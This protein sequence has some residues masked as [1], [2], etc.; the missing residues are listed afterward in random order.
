MCD[1]I[2]DKIKRLWKSRET[3]LDVL[4]DRGY[5][6]SESHI[7]YEEFKEWADNLGE[8]IDER[9]IREEMRLCFE[10]SK[11]DIIYVYWHGAKLGTH[12]SEL[13]R[14]M[15]KNSITRAIIVSDGGITT[16]GK[17]CIK[18]LRKYHIDIYT[19]EESQIN[20]MKHKLQPRVSICSP[21]EKKRIMET[22][23]TKIKDYPFILKTD[24]IC[25]HFGAERGQ[26]LKIIRDSE[27]QL[28]YESI[29]Y[30]MVV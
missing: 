7:S 29:T 14:D 20:I 3:I 28:G 6:T 22:Y 27:T 2:N 17:Q 30:R 21:K 16:W 10:K 11:E 18:N 23:S 1:N 5:D 26:L 19:L 8:Y 12:L 13:V 15:E 4:A 24:K 9:N 25:R